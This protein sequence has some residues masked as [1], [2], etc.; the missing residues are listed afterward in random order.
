MQKLALSVMEL[1]TRVFTGKSSNEI[2]LETLRRNAV[3]Q[4]RK[5]QAMCKAQGIEIEIG[6]VFWWTPET[7]RNPAAQHFLH[8]LGY[9]DAVFH[10]PAQ[11]DGGNYQMGYQEGQVDLEVRK[12]KLLE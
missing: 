12:L 10:A 7:L 4:V 6:K 8:Q 2:Q 3:H 11:I 1:L 5:A 9:F